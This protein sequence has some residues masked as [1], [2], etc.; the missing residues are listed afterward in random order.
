MTYV[1]SQKSLDKLKGVDERLVNVV[2]RA[3]TYTT[4]DFSVGEG[5]RTLERQKELLVLKTT[6]TLKSK[7]L[8]GHAVDL[9]ALKDGVVSWD[10]ALYPEI[11]KAMKQ[12]AEELSVNIR[13]GGEFKSFYDGPHFELT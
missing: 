7:H 11:A 4:V 12:A 5:V 6:Q 3:I 9:Y 8:I 1:L 10:K 13:W 2:K